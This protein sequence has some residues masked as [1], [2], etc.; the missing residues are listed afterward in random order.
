LDVRHV[1]QPG[2]G[3]LHVVAQ[4]AVREAVGGEPVDD[5]ERV[6]EVVVEGGAHDALR[7]RVPD[8]ADLVADLL[9]DG[10]DLL[11]RRVAAQVHEDH[12]LPGVRVAAQ[13][14]ERRQLLEPALEPLGELEQRVVERRARPGGLHDHGADRE[15]RILVAA[16]R[17]EGGDAGSDRDDHEEGDQRAV[18][19]RPAREV[20]GTAWSSRTF[21]PGRRVCTPAVTTISSGAS[22]SETVTSKRSGRSTT[23]LRSDTVPLSASSTQTAGRPSAEVSAEA[24]MRMAPPSPPSWMLPVTV[25][26]RRIAAGGSARPTRTAKVRVTASAR[27]DTSRTRPIAVTAGSETSVTVTSGSRPPAASFTRAGTS[28]TASRPPSR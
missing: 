14:I 4:L 6:A 5:P 23:T 18:A 28:K 13:R 8:V 27:G 2:A 20:H 9:P 3:R 26:P 16:E 19:Q 10:G 1:E 11:R 24:G 17:E 21:W 12:R 7:Q 25:V 22:P 15:G